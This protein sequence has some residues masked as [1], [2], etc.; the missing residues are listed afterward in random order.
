MPDCMHTIQNEAVV[1]KGLKFPYT[2]S[3]PSVPTKLLLAPVGRKI[4]SQQ[5]LTAVWEA[6]L[7]MSLG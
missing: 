5:E 2:N 7:E 4:G 1:P 3:C 6:I